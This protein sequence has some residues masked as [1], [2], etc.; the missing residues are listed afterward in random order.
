MTIKV[1]ECI[2]LTL[3]PVELVPS[4]PPVFEFRSISPITIM[5]IFNLVILPVILLKMR[6]DPF[7]K[8]KSPF[9]PFFMFPFFLLYLS[10]IAPEKEALCDSGGIEMPPIEFYPP[11]PAEAELPEPV[12]PPP[13]PPEIPELA[14]PLML[15]RDR[16]RELAIGLSVQFIGRNSFSDLTHQME[17]LEMRVLIETRIEAAL[18]GDGYRA[19]DL[20]RKRFEVR[21]V[22]FYNKNGRPFSE[23]TLRRYLSQIDNSGTRSSLPYRKVVDSIRNYSI[24][25]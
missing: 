4:Q 17:I 21:D 18:I 20:I 8:D 12:S 5:L 6:G 10:F 25:L 15:D 23:Q 19:A 3:G 14:H 7:F 1:L 22:L 11:A 24:C 13:P 16:R 2:F 9:T